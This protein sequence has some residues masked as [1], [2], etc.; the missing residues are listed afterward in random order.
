MCII[1]IY[2]CVCVCVSST[3]SFVVSQL[4]S[5]ARHVIYIYIYIYIYTHKF[6]GV[7]E[8]VVWQVINLFT[9]I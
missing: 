9:Y 1:Y 6:L 5:V 3:D 7:F 4:F 2:V 8:G